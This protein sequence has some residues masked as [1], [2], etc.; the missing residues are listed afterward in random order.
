MMRNARKGHLWSIRTT[1]VLIRLCICTGWSGSLL[2]T[3]RINGYCSICRR[4][5]NV[6][7]RLH[8]CARSSWP[9]LFRYDIKAF[10]AHFALIILSIPALM[11]W[12]ATW[13]NVLSEWNALRKLA[14]SNILKILYPKIEN[15]QIKY[16]DS[17]HIPAQNIECGHSLE[18]PRR[19]GS[20]EFPQSMF[21][22]SK[23]RK[24]NVYPCKP[25][26]MFFCFFFFSKLRK[27]NVYPCKPQ[28]HYIKVGVKRGGGV[29]II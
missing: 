11:I 7:I 15:F 9:S 12:T 27:N 25:Q 21:F 13:E 1:Q 23:I 20:N 6:R 24:N 29:K 22:F 2:P 4:T 17:F 3:T 8:R 19:D 14:Y 18:P 5:E 10:L 16:S 26:S 28:F